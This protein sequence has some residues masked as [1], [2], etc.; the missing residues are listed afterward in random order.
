MSARRTRLARPRRASVA[1]A[2]LVAVAAVGATTVASAQIDQRRDA[3]ATT[4]LGGTVA[5]ASPRFEV[6]PP[7]IALLTR[8]VRVENRRPGTVVAQVRR[9]DGG[10]A[11]G[12]PV[13]FSRSTPKAQRSWTPVV[14][15]RTDATGRAAARVTVP[16]STVLAASA[17]APAVLGPSGAVARPATRLVATARTKVTV[18]TRPTVSR[19]GRVL[20]VAA[21][22]KGRPYRY[23]AVGPSAFDCSGYTRYVFAKAAGRSLPHSSSAQY[24]LS[25]K[26]SKSQIR[27]G[28]LVFFRSG[29]RVY[30]VGI[31]AGNGLIWHA[32]HTGAVVRL[33]P[34]STSSW[35]AGRVL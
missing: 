22:L 29:S 34:I 13:T 31:Y 30:H 33:A 3:P 18:V 9:S 28:D 25:T 6:E 19:A 1:V 7:T 12:V 4:L 10:P 35:V 24:A 8:A 15:V 16:S 21:S 20:A 23:A 27:P 17:V 26:I 14:T 32:P 2:S 5:S 11:V